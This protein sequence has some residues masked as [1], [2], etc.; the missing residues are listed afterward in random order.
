MK[1]K[2]L[3]GRGLIWKQKIFH[4]QVAWVPNSKC[5]YHYG[6]ILNQATSLEIPPLKK[7]T[8]ITTQLLADLPFGHCRWL[9]CIL[10]F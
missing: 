9:I 10:L 1:H 8:E 5:P 2:H 4:S 7:A 6:N 3:T